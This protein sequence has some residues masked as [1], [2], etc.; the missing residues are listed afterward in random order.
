MST[1]DTVKTLA[2]ATTNAVQI[3]ALTK[4][5]Q[6]RKMREN[7]KLTKRVAAQSARR[8]VAKRRAAKTEARQAKQ[9]D[10]VRKA[11]E[12]ALTSAGI[13]V[14]SESNDAA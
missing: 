2:S 6:A 11:F 3:A 5:R 9:A 13:N 8:D 10:K 14:E 7:H 12:Q 4:V 1:T